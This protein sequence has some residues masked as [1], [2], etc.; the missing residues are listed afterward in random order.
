MDKKKVLKAMMAL[1]ESHHYPPQQQVAGQPLDLLEYISDIDVVAAIKSGVMF[2]YADIAPLGI[3]KG[4]FRELQEFMKGA[5]YT[6]VLRAEVQ[7]AVVDRFYFTQKHMIAVQCGIP[8]ICFEEFLAQLVCSKDPD[9]QRFLEGTGKV[10]KEKVMA[11]LEAN[12]KPPT[13]KIK[14]GRRF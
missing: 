8:C 13:K 7:I 12:K 5:P 4:M 2:C 11:L 14:G 9:I 10:I 1:D 3:P 6:S